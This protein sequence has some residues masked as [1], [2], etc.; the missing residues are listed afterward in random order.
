MPIINDMYD[1]SFKLKYPL[2]YQIQLETWENDG[3]NYST[4]TISGLTKPDV[5][6]YIAVAMMFTSKNNRKNGGGMGN[7]ENHPSHL[8]QV[9]Q[10]K[11]EEHPEISAETKE[12][13]LEA[14]EETIHELLVEHILGETIDYEDYDCFCRVFESF[15]VIEIREPVFDI[16]DQ[17]K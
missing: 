9:I 3:D 11:V 6:F 17:F 10:E 8:L 2:G 12:I 7:S 16:T 13:W 4:Q 14:D 15:K 1:V 5:I